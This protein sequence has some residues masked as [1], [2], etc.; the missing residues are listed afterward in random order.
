MNDAT[1]GAVLDNPGAGPDGI[2]G[3]P[4]DTPTPLTEVSQIRV[5]ITAR[6]T[7]VDSRG[8]PVRATQTSTFATKNLGF[9]VN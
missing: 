4:D 6:T 8:V 1:Y 5:T 2:A 3:S 7:E 9:D